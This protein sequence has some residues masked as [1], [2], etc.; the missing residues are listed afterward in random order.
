MRSLSSSYSGHVG[1]IDSQE[2]TEVFYQIKDRPVQ[3]F[4]LQS[5]RGKKNYRPCDVKIF[6]GAKPVGVSLIVQYGEEY[7][8]SMAENEGTFCSYTF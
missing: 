6:N 2:R 5:L 7:F 1:G 8:L 3:S 4:I